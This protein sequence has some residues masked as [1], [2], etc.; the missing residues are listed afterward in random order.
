MVTFQLFFSVQGTG[1]SLTGPNPENRVEDQVGQFLL[2]CKCTVSQGIVMQEQDPLVTFPLR[3]YH[4]LLRA[5]TLC[6]LTTKCIH[7]L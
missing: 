2:S 1:G 6:I 3:M 7:V 4:L 5:H